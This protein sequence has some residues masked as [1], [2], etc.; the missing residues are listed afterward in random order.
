MMLTNPT[1]AFYYHY[2]CMNLTV[3]L[4]GFQMEG[5]A[6]RL[7]HVFQGEYVDMHEIDLDGAEQ[8]ICRDCVDDIWMGCQPD[9]LTNVV[10]YCV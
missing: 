4:V 6:P 7:K 2:S 10:H 9:K 8:N 3:V 1:M 5:C